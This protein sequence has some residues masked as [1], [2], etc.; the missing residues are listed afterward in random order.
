VITEITEE[1]KAKA[2]KAKVEEEARAKAE[3]EAKAKA[4][5][6]AKAK[7]KK[8]A[9]T[10]AEE[11]AKAKA[12][13]EARYTE[14]AIYVSTTV[15]VAAKLVL[16]Q[17]LQT[18]L[19]APVETHFDLHNELAHAFDIKSATDTVNQTIDTQFSSMSN[20]SQFKSTKANENYALDDPKTVNDA[21][22]KLG[23]SKGR[24]KE[25]N[26]F[27]SGQYFSDVKTDLSHMPSDS[28]Q[29]ATAK[30]TDLQ[31]IAPPQPTYSTQNSARLST[32]YDNAKDPATAKS[33]EDLQLLLDGTSTNVK[34]VVEFMLERYTEK[35][36]DGEQVNQARVTIANN[37][38]MVVSKVESSPKL[39]NA[40]DFEKVLER[41]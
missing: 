19:P 14:D 33:M 29:S 5:E 31:P 24:T 18:Q 41:T 22:D 37:I 12:E 3:K 21:Y 4:E 1:T 39:T 16:D 36:R 27:K 8:E 25:Q 28:L 17:S 15:A 32:R 35:S 20:L 2:E 34:K 11:E 26:I 23:D 10:K 38:A 9:K 40:N 7:A 6:E 30:D 13:R